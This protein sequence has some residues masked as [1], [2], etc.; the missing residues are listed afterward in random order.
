MVTS[1]A[2]APSR[3]TAIQDFVSVPSAAVAVLVYSTL[4]HS[5]SQRVTVYSRDAPSSSSLAGRAR[6]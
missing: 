4:T 5:A 1:V 2:V 3:F 6:D